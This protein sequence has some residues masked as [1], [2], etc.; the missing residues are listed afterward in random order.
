MNC[1]IG[2]MS[3]LLLAAIAASPALAQQ[4]TT[5]RLDARWKPFTGCWASFVSD[6]RGPDVCVIPTRDSSVVELVALRRDS[7]LSRSTV[8]ASERRETSG[9]NECTGFESARW[10][11]DDRRMY[12]L[13][14]YKCRGTGRRQCSSMY[15]MNSSTTFSRMESSTN[16]AGTTLRTI[17]F[18]ALDTAPHLPEELRRRLPDAN[19]R[20]M[21]VARAVASAEL[22][23]AD[24]A[25]A[26]TS[27]HPRLVAEWLYERGAQFALSQLG[28]RDLREAGFSPEVVVAINAMS[29][30]ERAAHERERNF[31]AG[32]TVAAGKAQRHGRDEAA[33]LSPTRPEACAEFS[34][35]KGTGCAR[36]SAGG[37][38]GNVHFEPPFPFG[39]NSTPPSITV[40]L[41]KP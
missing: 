33:T 27:F 29:S 12:L 11:L 3:G 24:V 5:V 19:S 35:L 25:D 32:G 41:P 21:W 38:L 22:S 9:A 30:P 34:H 36:V 1:T 13:A 7:V 6:V 40:T 4:D 37:G 18:V 17:N 8:T 14:S 20:S 28:Q 23:T 2:A 10:S 31:G 26:A 15:T 39:S 16:D